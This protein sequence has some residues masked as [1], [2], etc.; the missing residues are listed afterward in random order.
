MK[1]DYTT[2][3]TGRICELCGIRGF[4]GDIC[5]HNSEVRP[6]MVDLKS[7]PAEE[8]RGAIK[9]LMEHP[10]GDVI[11]KALEEHRE[12]K[13]SPRSAFGICSHYLSV[14]TALSTEQS[15]DAPNE[16]T[17]E[18]CVRYP[19]DCWTHPERKADYYE[20]LATKQTLQLT[21][22]QVKKANDH[23]G[24]GFVEML[25]LVGVTVEIVA[26]R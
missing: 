17:C 16:P 6:L 22:A 10:L 18:K 4:A 7:L 19:G 21:R 1:E 25:S 15:F 3:V 12:C 26:D 11:H 8:R 20:K 14:L 23:E 9:A 5:P 13:A 24:I 2:E